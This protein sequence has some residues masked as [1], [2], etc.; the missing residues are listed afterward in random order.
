MLY[1]DGG[2]HS[3]AENMALD[4]LLLQAFKPE[5]ALRF[6]H[7]GWTEPSVT[8]GFSQPL[9]WIK[10]QSSREVQHFVRRPS[11]GGLVDHR[12]DWTYAFVLPAS[13]PLVRAHPEGV[14]ELVHEALAMAFTQCGCRASTARARKEKGL[15]GLCFAS[16]EVHDVVEEETGR[17]IAGAAMKRN[18]H[19]LLMQG[20]VDRAILP[21]DFD[22]QSFAEKTVRNLCLRFG[23]TD[24]RRIE[25]PLY[26]LELLQAEIQ[27]FSSLEWNGRR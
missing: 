9:E 18:R 5:D 26:P 1:H 12:N 22:W 8:F 2:A 24:S 3:A 7:Y 14:Y 16:P 4:V 10:G 13:H 21:S 20:S 17:K 11:G 25:P 15:Q 27:R 19:G 6:R 23:G